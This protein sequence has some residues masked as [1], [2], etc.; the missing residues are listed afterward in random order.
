MPESPTY[1]ELVKDVSKS[2]GLVDPQGVINSTEMIRMIAG[3]D[4]LAGIVFHSD[5]VNALLKLKNEN[6]YLI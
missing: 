5:A 6:I 3:S 2:L 1:A 4:I